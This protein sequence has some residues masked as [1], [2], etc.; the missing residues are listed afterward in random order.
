MG[1]E[2]IRKERIKRKRMYNRTLRPPIFKWQANDSDRWW[3]APA[4]LLSS[5]VT[6]SK[7]IKHSNSPFAYLYNGYNRHSFLTR[8]LTPLLPG[9][10]SG[11]YQLHVIWLPGHV[12]YWSPMLNVMTCLTFPGYFYWTSYGA[13]TCWV[14][15]IMQALL[16]LKANTKGEK[17]VP[18][19][20]IWPLVPSIHCNCRHVPLK[21]NSE[22]YNSKHLKQGLRLRKLNCFT[23]TI[24][25]AY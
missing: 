17:Y 20:F 15:I 23:K 13:F 14:L 2:D 24:P 8:Q 22:R 9:R 12:F 16:N 25:Y 1:K 6:L 10:S 11:L 19:S 18:T 5:H 21:G 4:L 3:K 7:L